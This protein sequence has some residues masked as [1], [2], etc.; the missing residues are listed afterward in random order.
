[1]LP[2]LTLLVLAAV[3]GLLSDHRRSR[4]RREYLLRTNQNRAKA[5]LEYYNAV[6]DSVTG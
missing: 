1:V 2:F 4:L 3:L 5:S 6:H